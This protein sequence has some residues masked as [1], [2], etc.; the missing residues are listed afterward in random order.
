MEN[1]EIYKWFIIQPPILQALYAGLFT[2]GLT[3]FGAALVFLFNSSILFLISDVLSKIL[4]LNEFVL[5]LNESLDIFS[6]PMKWLLILSTRGVIFFKS[7]PDLSPK[8][9]FKIE[10]SIDT[11]FFSNLFKKTQ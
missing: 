9:T 5:S 6:R 10:L 2:W 3:A 4:F 7:L 1:Y 8:K 11:V